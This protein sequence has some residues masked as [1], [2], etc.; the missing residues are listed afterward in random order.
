MLFVVCDNWGV[1]DWHL[2]CSDGRV[3]DLAIGVIEV[4]WPEIGIPVMRVM[5]MVCDWQTE[6]HQMMGDRQWAINDRRLV[7]KICVQQWPLRSETCKRRLDI[8]GQRDR[9]CDM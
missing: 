9:T 8:G 6:L 7:M 1:C 4:G 5:C 2:G 3:F